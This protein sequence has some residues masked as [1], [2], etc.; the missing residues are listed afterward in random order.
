MKLH[1]IK[2]LLPLTEWAIKK[3]FG[4]QKEKHKYPKTIGTPL[5]CS[6]CT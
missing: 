2:I 4:V 1:G 5:T 6:P 3:P